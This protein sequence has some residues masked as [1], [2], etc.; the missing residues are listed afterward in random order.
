M[1]LL[2]KSEHDTIC[3]H[4]GKRLPGIKSMSHISEI[5]GKKASEASFADFTYN[6][7]HILRGKLSE[8]QQQETI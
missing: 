1:H 6:E 5:R 3:R 8:S 4:A 7:Q 2:L